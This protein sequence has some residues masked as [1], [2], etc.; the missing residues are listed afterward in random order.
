MAMEGKQQPPT[1][2]TLAEKQIAINPAVTKNL[3][4]NN[5]YYK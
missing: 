2:D 3:Q 1:K 4:E 5:K